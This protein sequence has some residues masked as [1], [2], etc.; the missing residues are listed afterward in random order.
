M[1]HPPQLFGSLSSETHT[2]P[3]FVCVPGHTIAPQTPPPASGSEQHAPF[4][5]I[6]VDEEHAMLHPPQFIGSPVMSR[7]VPPQHA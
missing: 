5:Q 3:Q 2:P 6:G 4:M 7:H 1:S